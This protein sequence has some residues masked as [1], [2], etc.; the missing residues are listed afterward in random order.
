[1][2]NHNVGALKNEKSTIYFGRNILKEA[3]AAKIQIDEIFYDTEPAKKYVEGLKEFKK[4]PAPLRPELPK[5]VR[6]QNHQGIAFRTSHSFYETYRIE[7][8]KKFPI[9]IL[10][11]QIEDV[12]NLGSI[13]RCAAGFGAKWIIHE[14]K[15]SA[16]VTAAVVKSSAGLAFGLRF[17]KVSNLQLVC[18]DLA[19][20]GFHLVGLDVTPHAISLFD[21]VPTFPLALILGS[22]SK[23][24]ESSIKAKCESL[25]RIPMETRV[26]SLNVSHAAAIALSWIY[27][28]NQF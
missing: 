20:S 26:E 18:K 23:G 11:N 19:Q 10:C 17:S 8:L 15:K 7:N 16:E 27:R 12:H 28:S 22:E 14:E 1:M 24:M 6:Q 9:I 2:K 21:W 3:L 13:A 4:R 5:E 25:I